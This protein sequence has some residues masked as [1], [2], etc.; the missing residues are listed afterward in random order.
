[1]T[2]TSADVRREITVKVS[3]ERAFDL[4]TNHMHE[5]W[6]AEHHIATSPVVAMTVEPGVGGR[7]FDQCED[8]GESVWGQ[9]TEWDPPSRFCFGWMLTSTWQAETDVEK[10]SRVSVSFIPDGEST[11]VVLVHND[12]WRLGE[13]GQA[14]AE[15]VGT[16]D[17]WS[18]GLSR[19][20]EFAR[21]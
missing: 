11:R 2:T 15:A 5:W 19:F 1:M 14:M 3:R 16:P 20:A 18:R 13:G 6:P 8:G 4:F 9:V 17:G 12:F 7:L 21:T 10:A